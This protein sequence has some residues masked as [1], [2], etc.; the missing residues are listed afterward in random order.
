MQL[1][2][3]VMLKIWCEVDLGAIVFIEASLKI[4]NNTVGEQI[5]VEQLTEPRKVM[6]ISKA[7]II[8]I[9]ITSGTIRPIL[10]ASTT[11]TPHIDR[12]PAC[13]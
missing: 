2:K 11:F 9:G 5:T 4:A 13:I 8:H 7:M 10:S 12:Y 6:T 3:S 1:S